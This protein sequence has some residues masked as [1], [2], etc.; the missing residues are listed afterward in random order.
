MRLVIAGG[1]PGALATARAYRE[2]G[3]D[4]D[5]TLI[6]PE[7][8]LPYT[9]PALSK[10]F[11]RGEM[12]GGRAGDRAAGLVRRARRRVR[13]GTDLVTAV[14]DGEVGCATRRCASTPASSPPA[15]AE[16]AGGARGRVLLLRSLA[17]AR[18]LRDAAR[19]SRDRHRLGLHRLR[20][21]GLAGHARPGRHARLRRGHPHATRLGEDAGRRIL[22]WLEALGVTLALG[23][24]RSSEPPRRPRARAYGASASTSSASRSTSGCARSGRTSTPSATSPTP[25]TPPPAAALAVEHWG[26]ALNMG[27]VAGSTLAGEDAVWD[28]APGFWSTI[29]EQTLKYVAWGDG[30]DEAHLTDHGGGAW[31]VRYERE[32]ARRRAHPRS[33]RGLRGRPR[34]ARGP[35]MKACVVV[36]ARDEEELIGAC[37]A[38]L[39]AQTGSPGTTTRSC[40][41]STAAPTR[42]R[43]GPA[44]PRAT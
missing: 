27:E 31:T 23:R 41:C 15:R 6:T 13:L 1:G 2:A 9:R 38:A 17:D 30:F 39:A 29:G 4:G 8:A 5:V 16:A 12:R 19:E 42:P 37:I 36:P 40:S 3:G 26:E 10:E 35:G 43:R 7:A 18:A 44:P 33:R 24:E 25:T 20:G 14:R 21:G 34:A 32:G 22:G 28:V 11:L